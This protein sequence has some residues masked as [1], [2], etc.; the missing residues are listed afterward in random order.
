M[1]Q[2]TAGHTYINKHGKLCRLIKTFFGDL[3][4]EIS[5]I[6]E[7]RLTP[8]NSIM[9]TPDDLVNQGKLIRLTNIKK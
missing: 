6:H 5:G 3:S 4:T 9:V 8:Q 2:I 7:I 1:K